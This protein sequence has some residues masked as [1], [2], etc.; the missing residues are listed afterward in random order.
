MLK[1]KGKRKLATV[2]A[3]II[4]GRIL[5]ELADL[6][7]MQNFTD[8]LLIPV[9]L[10]KDRQKE[11]GFNQAELICRE[12]TKLDNNINFSLKTDI[13]IKI[14]NTKHQAKVE[15]RSERLR[16]I[17]GSFGINEKQTDTK[18]EG[19]NIILI[20][21]VITTGATLTEAKKILKRAGARKVVAFTVA[22]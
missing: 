8:P 17:I 14:K 2:F 4:Y 12:L 16:N 18:L 11:R 1:Y 5:E 3:E 6:Q 13:L 7:V 15:N 19:R 9:P 10:E 22:H 21:D 20:D